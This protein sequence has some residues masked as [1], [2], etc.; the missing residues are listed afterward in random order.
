MFMEISKGKHT[1]SMKEI[2]KEMSVE[3]IF[4]KNYLIHYP[5]VTKGTL[6]G[7]I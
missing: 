4:S 5:R 3:I 7:I 1:E 2:S 6:Q